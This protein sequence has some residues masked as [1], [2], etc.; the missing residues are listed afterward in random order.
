MLKDGLRPALATALAAAALT[1]AILPVLSAS[2]AQECSCMAPNEA[3]NYADADVVFK[4]TANGATSSAVKER[5]KPAQT[6][7]LHYQFEPITEYKGN[8]SDPQVVV[9]ADNSASCGVQLDGPGPYLVFANRLDSE[10]ARSAGLAPGDLTMNL[11]GGTRPIGADEEPSFEP[12][13]LQ[14]VAPAAPD[15]T[16][17]PD[18]FREFLVDEGQ[19]LVINLLNLRPL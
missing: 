14:S 11:C 12:T 2:A 6:S 1:A 8:V 9:T 18:A 19:N 7:G 5:G 16:K 10:E 17:D 3:K 13:P 15:P 4:G